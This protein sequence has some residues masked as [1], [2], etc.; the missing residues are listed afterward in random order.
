ME[1]WKSVKGFEKYLAVSDEGRVKSFLRHPDGNILK[2]QVDNKGYLR[3]TCTIEGE[4]VRFKVHRLVAEH[5]VENPEGKEQVNHK[6]GNKQNNAVSNLEWVTAS[7]NALHA[8]HNGLWSAQYASTMRRNQEKITPIIATDIET[9]EVRY[10]KSMREAE[11]EIGTRHI[12]QVIRGLRRQAK[13][14]TFR[15]AKGGDANVAI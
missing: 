1:V 9:G 6:D 11:R 12:N 2:A 7:E 15:Y 13:G 10:F 5:F 14:Y 3:L 4:K 8:V